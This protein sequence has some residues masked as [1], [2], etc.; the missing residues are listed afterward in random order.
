[1]AVIKLKAGASSKPPSKGKGD[2]WRSGESSRD[3]KKITDDLLRLEE[4]VLRQ[5]KK[6]MWWAEIYKGILTYFDQ[7][8]LTEASSRLRER[9]EQFDTLELREIR[10]KGGLGATLSK[11]QAR[12][13]R[14]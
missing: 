13:G 8:G 9:K 11:E 4:V 3:R 6:L 2:K 10:K 12:E 14:N 5:Q 7:E 1:M